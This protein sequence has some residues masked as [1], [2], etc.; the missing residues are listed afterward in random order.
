MVSSFLGAFAHPLDNAKETAARVQAAADA[1]GF[2]MPPI[3]SQVLASVSVAQPQEARA[4]A[5]VNASAPPASIPAGYAQ[6]T[7]APLWSRYR[8]HIMI[9]AAIL[10]LW[11]VRRPRG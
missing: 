5:R 2:N 4:A 9:G 3:L 10:A 11:L 8:I 7:L 6:S 1:G